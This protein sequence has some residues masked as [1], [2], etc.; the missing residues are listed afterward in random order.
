MIDNLPP[1]LAWPLIVILWAGV[2]FMFAKELF[3]QPKD[4]HGSDDHNETPTESSTR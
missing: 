3:K 2:I 1:E 4:P